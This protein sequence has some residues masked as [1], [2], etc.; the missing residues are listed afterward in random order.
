M[1]QENVTSRNSIVHT[2]SYLDNNTH[3]QHM[4]DNLRHGE[5][6]DIKWH[7]RYIQRRLHV[8]RKIQHLG[9][10]RDQYFVDS[11]PELQ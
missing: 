4:D 2:D 1:G 5:I 3:V 9:T 11:T 7:R 10:L 8:G 6:R